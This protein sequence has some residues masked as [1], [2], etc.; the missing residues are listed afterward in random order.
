MYVKKLEKQSFSLSLSLST[1]TKKENKNSGHPAIVFSRGGR[2]LPLS[3][4]NYH[5]NEYNPKGGYCNYPFILALNVLV[6]NCVFS[7]LIAF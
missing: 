4:I 5:G 6:H 2:S 7:T 3:A 1:H